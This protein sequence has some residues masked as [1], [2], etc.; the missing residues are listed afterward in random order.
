ME[1]DIPETIP[2][3]T[4]LKAIRLENNPSLEGNVKSIGDNW[5]WQDNLNMYKYNGPPQQQFYMTEQLKV[6]P[7]IGALDP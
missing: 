1:G 2:Q 3:M 5:L 4:D 6:L 7:E